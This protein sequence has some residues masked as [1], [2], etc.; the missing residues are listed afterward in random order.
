M[1]ATVTPREFVA[2]WGQIRLKEM[3]VSQIRFNDICRLIGH[4][5]PAET[6]LT[7]QFFTFEDS[8]A[9]SGGGKG[10]H[11]NLDKAYQQLQLYHELLGN[12][13][14]LITSD[15]QHFIIDTNFLNMDEEVHELGLARIIIENG[16]ELLHCAFYEQY[17]F[18]LIQ[19]YLDYFRTQLLKQVATI[20]HHKVV[21][22]EGFV[23]AILLTSDASL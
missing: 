10:R 15:T 12:S 23:I 3:T 16:V 7:G 21:K 20:S 13:H 11:A 6:G 2:K 19:N 8:M 4:L 17:T 22:I 1:P 14:L 9:K 5:A 18:R